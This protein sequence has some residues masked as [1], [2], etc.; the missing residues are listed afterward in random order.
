MFG[1]KVSPRTVR[2]HVGAELKQAKPQIVDKKH[3]DTASFDIMDGHL[4]KIGLLFKAKSPDDGERVLFEPGLTIN[5]D[6]K[7]IS[8]SKSKRTRKVY[9][10]ASDSKKPTIKRDMNANPGGHL[11]MGAFL[12]RDG[13]PLGPEAYISSVEYTTVLRHPRVAKTIDN[14]HKESPIEPYFQKTKKGCT[15][16]QVTILHI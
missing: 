15:I 12:C 5:Y 8:G 6:E 4:K 13:Q 2:R 14:Y 3:S 11:T 9:I 16:L 1:E 7:N 10:S